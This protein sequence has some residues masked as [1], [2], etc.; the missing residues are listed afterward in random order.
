MQKDLKYYLNLPYKISVV[1]LEDGDY[2]AK[3][4][5]RELTKKTLMCGVGKNAN[6][7][8]KDLWDCFS[9]FVEEA[10]NSKEKIP[11]PRAKNKSKNIAITLKYSLIE[12]I[13]DCAKE[14]G[15]SRSAFLALCAKNYMRALS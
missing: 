5:D 14:L 2:Y 10:L 12:E 15:I 13:D 4:E 9:C 7:A 1:K 8:I 11:E 3:F 6:E